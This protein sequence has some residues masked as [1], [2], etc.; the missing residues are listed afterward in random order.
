M[1]TLRNAYKVSLILICSHHQ[2]PRNRRHHLPTVPQVAL[3][4]QPLPHA[5]TLS[6]PLPS[7][8]RGWLI[9]P[10]H[11]CRMTGI[12]CHNFYVY[13]GIMSNCSLSYIIK[14]A[15]RHVVGSAV[16]IYQRNTGFIFVFFL[17][18][19]QPLFV[20]DFPPCGLLKF[21]R[22]CSKLSRSHL[23]TPLASPF[24]GVRE[25]TPET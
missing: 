18:L 22:H 5:S 19:S 1:S 6:S 4:R 20:A 17:R 24:R 23:R 3:T 25:K 10:L 8:L 21:S 2:F 9:T 16:E 15:K 7:A 11:R 12:L 13:S 14:I